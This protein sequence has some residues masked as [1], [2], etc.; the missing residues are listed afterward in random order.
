MPSLP[1]MLLAYENTTQRPSL[2]QPIH[3]FVFSSSTYR[4][5]AIATPCFLKTEATKDLISQIR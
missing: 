3:H 2:A 4:A 1:A 5:K